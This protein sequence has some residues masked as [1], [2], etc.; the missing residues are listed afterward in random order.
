VRIEATI[1]AA[2]QQELSPRIV[3]LMLRRAADG[4][5]RYNEDLTKVEDYVM[6]DQKGNFVKL[7]AVKEE[8]LVEATDAE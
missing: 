6:S 5:V 8:V 1:H 7:K 2:G 4:L 3:G